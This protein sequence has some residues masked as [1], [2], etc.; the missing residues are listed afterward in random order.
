MKKLLFIA[1]LCVATLISCSNEKKEIPK[2]EEFADVT[3][4][5]NAENVMNSRAISDGTGA[6][7]L[8]W[9]VFNEAGELIIPKAIKNDANGLTY[10][11]GYTMSISLAKGHTYQVAFWAQNSEC[12]A[13]EVSDDMKVSINYE[14]INNDETRDAFFA[15]TEKFNVDRSSTIS[16]ILKRPFAQVNVGAFP[17]DWEN[18][19]D[20]GVDIS[21]SGAT[22]SGIANEL[23][24]LDG[25]VSGEVKVDYSFNALPNEDLKVDVDENNV[26]EIYKYLSMSYILAD[27]AS[28]T[29]TM[30]FTFADKDGGNIIT[31]DNGLGAVPIQR[32]WRTNIVGQILTGDITFNIKIDPIY[33]GETINSAG[34]YYNFSEDTTVKDKVFAFNTYEWATFT[35]ENNN[36]LTLDNVTFSGKV[37]QIAIGEY[38][39][40]QPEDVPY[41][42]I[43]KNV[44]AENMKVMSQLKNDGNYDVVI[45]NVQGID[46]MALLLYLRGNL[47][48]SDCVFTGTTSDIKTYTDYYGDVREVITYDCGFPNFSAATIDN[49]TIGKM[50]AWS[51][52]QITITNSKVDYI[53]CSTHNQNYDSFLVIDEGTEVEE[54]FVSS[55]GQAKSQKGEDNKKHWVDLESNQWAPSLIIK[56]GAKVKKLDMNGRGRYNTVSAGSTTWESQPDV[57][58]EEGAI[59]EEI[60]NEETVNVPPTPEP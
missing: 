4:T 26:D 51:H 6:N 8:M 22:I 59:V 38:R 18:A 48:I 2:V 24:L 42:N 49:C 13:Y 55:S 23:N 10:K 11:D 41:T 5:L 12:E 1:T 56:A 53:R 43:L 25:S 14:G 16:V 19:T 50:Y 45:E 57:I 21:Q 52:S 60:V 33:E 36:L 9:G 40:K 54:I 47:T 34:L 46:C 15:V 35:T 28:S 3:F 31:F 32:N 27:V 58:I 29:H 20:M 39:G 17:F 30:S 37:G 44:K 7:Q